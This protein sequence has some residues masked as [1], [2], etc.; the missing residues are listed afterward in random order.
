M[1]TNTGSLEL[2]GEVHRKR[3]VFC[4]FL[5]DMRDFIVFVFQAE[6]ILYL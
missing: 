2:L 1:E 6:E 5:K 4:G 3:W